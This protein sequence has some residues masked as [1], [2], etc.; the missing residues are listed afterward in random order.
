MPGFN[1]RRSEWLPRSEKLKTEYAQ[2]VRSTGPASYRIVEVERSE[3]DDEDEMH[4]SAWA[5]QIISLFPLTAIASVYFGYTYWRLQF[6]TILQLRA[7]GQDMS[8]RLFFCVLEFLTVAP[9]F[10]KAILDAIAILF[11]SE[12]RQLRLAGLA[13]PSVDII[14]T[15]CKEDVDIILDT[16]R[17][18]L[19][20]EYPIDKFRV[21][22]TDDGGSSELA[23]AIRNLSAADKIQ[24]LFYTC[25]TKGPND[26]NKAGNI[27][28]ALRFSRTLPG[29]SYEFA[30]GLD[31]DMIPTR[32]FLRAQIPHLLLDPKMGFT[33]PAATFYNNP[34]NDP[35][36]QTQTNVNKF[37]EYIKDR[38]NSAWCT[39]SGWVM[40]RAALDDVDGFPGQT[41][42]EDVHCSSKQIGKGWNAAFIAESLQYGLMPESYQGHLKQ[43]RRW[44]LG[45]LE[46]GLAM[47]LCLFGTEAKCMGIFQRLY[48]LYYPVKSITAGFATLGLLTSPA[49]LMADVPIVVFSGIPELKKLTQAACVSYAC[50][51]L[52]RF[53]MSALT[54]YKASFMEL[55]TEI[56]MAPYHTLTQIQTFLLPKGF[57]GKITKFI[58]TGTIQDSLRERDQGKRAP[59]HRRLKNILFEQGA[60][61][62]LIYVVMCL[63]AVG[64]VFTRA[65]TRFSG[66]S[67]AFY[68]YLLTHIGWAPLPWL[69]TG[70]A[71]LTPLRYALFPPDVAP[72]EELLSRD[73][74]TNVAYPIE[75]AKRVPWKYDMFGYENIP[76]AVLVY[77]FALL[78]CT[79]MW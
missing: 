59:L 70:A 9:N 54:G 26:G 52:L 39:G 78:Y 66:D 79:R 35:L 67:T 49:I 21:I 30:A 1:L 45:G 61:F 60:I 36:F 8:T 68:L 16:V 41:L 18:A 3:E 47:K 62:H 24:R 25:R 76:L 74:V 44:K 73:P 11:G 56:W 57:G 51:W 37:D 65:Y 63:A 53:H 43:H 69:L 19:N 13:A 40:R 17:G 42:S 14:I 50:G 46:C 77:S 4:V 2:T 23:D 64:T 38:M 27:N 75:T 31:A 72:R 20:I 10:L 7:A 34:I 28:H 6:D 5:R 71:C 12:R 48:G 33:C 58:P 32:H 15:T 55:S 29:G 22:V